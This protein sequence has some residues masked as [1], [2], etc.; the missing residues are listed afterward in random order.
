MSEK[1]KTKTP[2]V[3]PEKIAT[4]LELFRTNLEAMRLWYRRAGPPGE[5]VG[6]NVIHELVMA[7]VLTALDY[8]MQGK[9]WV[10]PSHNA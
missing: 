3:E 5:V 4:T 1:T 6:L 10:A 9:T 8:A 2:K 7:N